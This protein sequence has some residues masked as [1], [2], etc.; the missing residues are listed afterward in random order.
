MNNSACHRHSNERINKK[1]FYGWMWLMQVLHKQQYYT[2]NELHIKNFLSSPFNVTWTGMSKRMELTYCGIAQNGSELI[3]QSSLHRRWKLKM[4]LKCIRVHKWKYWRE[5]TGLSL[6]QLRYS[7]KKPS[8]F[9]GK[10][11]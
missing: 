11:K 1:S 2:W 3:Y 8:N 9:L 7:T 5:K 10:V 6:N 4:A